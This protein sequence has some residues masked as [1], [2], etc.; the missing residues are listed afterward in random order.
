MWSFYKALFKSPRAVGAA[1]PSSL[2]LARAIASYIPQ[3]HS[4][5][6]VELGA[7]TG[8]VTQQILK[9]G[10]DPKQLIL[11]EHSEYLA[12]KLRQ[13]FP[14]V[15]TIH[16]NATKLVELL[17]NKHHNV[18]T[19]VSSLPLLSLPKPVTAKI[20]EQI[21]HIIKAHGT[22]I[23]YTFGPQ[24]S[25]FEKMDRYIKTASHQVWLNI[26]PARIDVFT[27]NDGES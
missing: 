6:I 14:A 15:K 22:Y 1:F 13:R 3:N 25:V 8:V 9:R 21:D 17:G 5:L 4:G 10:I 12:S 26:P 23:Q 20:I 18:A 16:G 11:I 2:F 7:G 24:K 19:I 27:V